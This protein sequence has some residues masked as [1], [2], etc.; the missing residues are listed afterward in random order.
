MCVRGCV[1]VGCAFLAGCVHLLI[2]AFV[3]GCFR[4]LR[5]NRSEAPLR[6]CWLDEVDAW[7]PSKKDGKADQ[8]LLKHYGVSEEVDCVS[9]TKH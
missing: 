8:R 1:R 5:V 7:Q 3:F 4:V 9:F 6:A 2:V